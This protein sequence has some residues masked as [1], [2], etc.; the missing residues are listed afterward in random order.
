MPRIYL[1]LTLIAHL[2]PWPAYAAV[3][4]ITDGDV[5]ALISAIVAA[6][7][8]SEAD[9][10][11]LA[12][13]GDYLLD[14]VEFGPDPTGLPQLASE[15]LINGNGATLR[16]SQFE[17]TPEFRNLLVAEAAVVTISDLIVR[18]GFTTGSGGGIK[19]AGT[20]TLNRCQVLD[21]Q[22]GEGGGIYNSGALTVTSS[23]I[24]GNLVPAGNGGGGIYSQGTNAV[25][26]LTDSTVSDNL[27]EIAP[28][29]GI[30][31]QV[32]AGGSGG[33]ATLTNSLI[34]DNSSPGANG[35][36]GGIDNDGSLI[37]SGGTISGNAASV[38]GGGIRTT[39]SLSIDGALI[40]ENSADGNGGGI[41]NY[42]GLVSISNTQIAAN[43]ATQTGGGIYHSGTRNTNSILTVSGS[44]IRD[45]AADSNGG[46]LWSERP[47]HLSETRITGNIAADGAGI[48]HSNNDFTGSNCTIAGNIASGNGGGIHTSRPVALDSCTL[49]GNQA[50]Q[51][52]GGLY[53][54]SSF[55]E[56]T[57]VNLTFSGNS[58]GASGG[59]LRNADG[60]FDLVT[61]TIAANQATTGGGLSNAQPAAK[62]NLDNSLVAGNT[63]GDVEG[64]YS[65]LGYNLVQ[66]GTGISHPTSLVADPLLLPLADNGGAT[67]THAL[68]TGSPAIGNGNCANDTVLIDQRGVVRP[69][70]PGCDIGA[71]EW[72]EFAADL[73][74]ADG[75]ES[76]P[77]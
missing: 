44:V 15:I 50:A 34:T 64:Q 29:G 55:A 10:I 35:R 8:N 43:S 6:N 62:G 61:T 48:H 14:S 42:I 69:Q 56:F 75:F 33:E 18:D 54:D 63:G 25:L 1:L 67:L 22:G 65:D 4:N 26:V 70:P 23:V 74:F 68:A 73:I 3:F 72:A 40:E 21:N 12:T 11:N 51:E 58:A 20:L 59:G 19:S 17:T 24:S 36:G 60:R 30:R 7:D 39:R 9:S 52:G 31:N 32:G 76:P 71:F 2:V 27:S 37:I 77:P 41:A 16:R 13:N 46:G 53:Q 28:G 38:D 5:V 57:G 45:N 47:V 49:S 66:D